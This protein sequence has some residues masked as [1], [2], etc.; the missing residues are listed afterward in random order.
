LKDPNVG[1]KMKITK[2]GN[3]ARSLAHNTLRIKSMLKLRDEI[4]TNSS[5]R[6]QIEF[7]LHNRIKK[8]IGAS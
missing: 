5:A 6:I 4:I 1:A 3:E 8:V 2:K 7:N